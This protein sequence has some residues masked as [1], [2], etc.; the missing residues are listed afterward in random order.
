MK[1]AIIPSL[2]VLFVSGCTTAPQFTEI[3]SDICPTKENRTLVAETKANYK[4]KTLYWCDYKHVYK[5]SGHVIDTVSPTYT[6]YDNRFYAYEGE[7]F[8]QEKQVINFIDD[9]IK[10]EVK[11][12]RL[13]KEAACQASSKCMKARES[14]KKKEIEQQAKYN[15]IC[16]SFYSDLE[17][18][19]NFELSRI[20][21]ARPMVTGTYTCSAQ[22]FVITP[23]G[24]QFKQVQIT[25]SPETGVYEYK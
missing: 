2:L 22:G 25:G 7:L 5:S 6:V 19:T 24:K 17:S 21:F 12:A 10:E 18:K 15:N 23:H 3:E 20:V 1:L 16:A 13:E 4:N 8:S 9:E 14:E 11:K